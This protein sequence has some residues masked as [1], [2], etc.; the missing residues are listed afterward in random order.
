MKTKHSK[1]LCIFDRK[2]CVTVYKMRQTCLQ[3]LTYVILLAIGGTGEY[4]HVVSVCYLR[5]HGGP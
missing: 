4:H 5:S 1:S 3:Y 2:H